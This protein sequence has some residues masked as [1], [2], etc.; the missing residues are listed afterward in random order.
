[1]R[2]AVLAGV[3]SVEHGAPADDEV[4]EMMAERG[5]FL[6]PTLS[7]SAGLSECI[8][9]ETFPY[10]PQVM[11][12]ER[13]LADATRKT[14]ARARELGVKIALGTDAANPRVCGMGAT[15]VSSSSWWTVDCRL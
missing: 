4:L 7:I 3:D 1:M 15:P 12:V 8:E 9:Q 13:R 10:A 2:N 14:V 11:E 6:V 5:T